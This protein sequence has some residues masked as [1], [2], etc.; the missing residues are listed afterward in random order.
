MITMIL[1]FYDFLCV[2]QTSPNTSSTTP[3]IHEST[4]SQSYITVTVLLEPNDSCGRSCRRNNCV[5]STREYAHFK[6]FSQLRLS[7]KDEP[8]STQREDTT[9]WGMER[10]APG[11]RRGI[12]FSKPARVSNSTEVGGMQRRFEAPSAQTKGYLP[13]PVFQCPTHR[14]QR[15]EWR[16]VKEKE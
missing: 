1:R 7:F 2:E 12:P 14:H 4:S 3:S 5:S 6:Y 15:Q 16:E 13:A 10:G 8:D 9:E 11:S